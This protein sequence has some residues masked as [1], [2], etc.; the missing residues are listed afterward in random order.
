[1]L[2]RSH[3]PP[4]LSL[5]VPRRMNVQAFIW[6]WS[7]V[8]LTERSASQQ[9]FLDLCEVVGHGK[10]AEL[11]PEG[12]SFT[13]EKGAAK[14]GGGRGW[15]DVWK[16]GFFAWEYKGHYSDL[17]AAYDQLLR[18]RE[19]LEN[20]PLL[21]VCDMDRLVVHTNFTG[22]PTVVHDIHLK[23]LAK[24]ENLEIVRAVFHDPERLK[25]GVTR[26]GI[27]R[28]AASRFAEIAKTLRDRGLDPR[29]VAR[30]LDRIVFLFFAQSVH[31][32]PDN[33]VVRLLRNSRES[34]EAFARV[35]SG[36]FE[37]M[38]HGGFFGVDQI[39]RFNGNLF[40]DADVLV[41][42]RDELEK[43][44]K[45]GRLDWSAIDPSI[46]GTLFERGLDPANRAELGAHYTSR[47]DIE[48]LVEPVV[49]APLRREWTEVRQTVENLLA[50][51]KKNPTEKDRRKPPI[52]GG[53]LRKAR[54]ESDLLIRRFWERLAHVRVLDPACGSGNFL[55]V[56][57]QKLKDLEKEVI[58]YAGEHGWPYIPLVG[59][60]QLY[61]IEINEY[62][63]ELAQM[64]V[65]IGYL[66]WIWNNGFGLKDDPVLRPMDSFECKD[67]ILDRSDPENPKEPEW[68]KVNFIVGNPPFLGGKRMRGA[69]IPDEYLSDLFRL[70][71]GRVPAESDLCCYW[72]EKAR[73]QIEIGQCERAGLLA[74]QAIRGGANRVVLER[75][76]STGSIFF[77]LSDREWVQDGVAVHVSMV[78]FGASEGATPVLD[79]REVEKIFSNLTA[80]VDVT[81]A[82]RLQDQV[83]LSFM[84]DTKGG[85]FEDDFENLAWM[86]SEPNPHGLPNSD[87]IRPWVNTSGLT[88]IRKNSLIIDFVAQA[89]SEVALYQA[90]FA[91]IQ[92]NVKESRATNRREAYR[93][94]W[95]R[96][97]EP[98]PG[99][100]A[101]LQGL[102]RYVVTPTVSKFRLFVWLDSP[103]L[104]DHQLIV[105]CRSDDYFLGVLHSRLH[106]TWA[107][108]QGTQLRERASGFRYIP[109]KTFETFPF[110]HPTPE[111]E[112]A[113]AAAAKELDNLRNRWLNPPEWTREEVLEFPGSVGGP[114]ARYVHDPDGRGI[115][116]VRYPRLVPRD[117]E[118]AEK[119]RERTLTN[120]YNQRP[121]WL[122]LAHRK[123]DEAVFAAY[124]WDPG[125]S[126][127]EILEKLLALNLERAGVSG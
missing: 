66:Q 48:T 74:T 62:A 119:L 37:A 69:G 67:A 105:F 15:A 111:Q 85:K 97:V 100:R 80:D 118:S 92:E 127:E 17:A 42:T 38:A 57:L 84:G 73:R 116:T 123:L 90:P 39:R 32:L 27:T 64:S 20:P 41:P 50:T 1:M 104:P 89:E 78:G 114:W 93:D 122:D 54:L 51:G 29:K 63:F 109:T 76:N 72:F 82:L 13:F 45:A 94:N 117:D 6:K 8:A 86:L 68:P 102:P 22:R 23:D 55:Y 43:I 34:P 106:E 108:S 3:D 21:V 14:Y 101:A 107:F 19:A 40:T 65:W 33:L 121:T 110:P 44:V 16:R 18:Y 124:R 75:I 99:L 95:W 26:E 70:W 24:P 61:G 30:F 49:L 10:P 12:D 52:E 120:L 7:K 115:G 59:P 11:D 53:T 77:A 125:I 113:I 96:H 56:T 46:L 103:V 81:A 58:L 79:G 126:D 91:F 9:H 60:W 28:D 47:E 98:R 31:L 35:L 87:V 2:S 25:P 36:L 4:S 5:P 112:T 71:E 83:D 88:R